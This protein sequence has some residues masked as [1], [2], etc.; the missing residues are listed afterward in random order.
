MNGNARMLPAHMLETV[1]V[2]DGTRLIQSTTATMIT[3]ADR[4]EIAEIFE[5][6]REAAKEKRSK[7]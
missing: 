6:S 7:K 4:R 3:E 5:R 1:S 2:V